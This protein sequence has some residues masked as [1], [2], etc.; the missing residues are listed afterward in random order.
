MITRAWSVA[1]S[2]QA[3]QT[4]VNLLFKPKYSQK[5]PDAHCKLDVASYSYVELQDAYLKQIQLIH[6]DKVTATTANDHD[7]ESY[8]NNE[9]NKIDQNKSSKKSN[10]NLYSIRDETYK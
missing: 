9:N 3:K 5:G 7:H 8:N 6:R 1:I 4:L 2:Q 10:R